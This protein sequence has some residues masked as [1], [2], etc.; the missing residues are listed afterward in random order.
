MSVD[1]A[2]AVSEFTL[3]LNILTAIALTLRRSKSWLAQMGLSSTRCHFG[4]LEGNTSESFG[5]DDCTVEMRIKISRLFGI[6]WYQTLAEAWR[7]HGIPEL[8]SFLFFLGGSEK[9]R[10]FLSY[11]LFNWSYLFF[12]RVT[13][14]KCIVCDTLSLIQSRASIILSHVFQL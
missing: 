8:F 5:K 3:G 7:G 14:Q 10:L 11:F 4:N 1:C 6:R 9:S 12:P 2:V 13:S